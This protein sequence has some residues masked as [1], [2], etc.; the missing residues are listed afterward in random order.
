MIM[1]EMRNDLLTNSAWRGKF[2]QR[3]INILKSEDVVSLV[4]AK[5][6]GNEENAV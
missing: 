3:L 4:Q 6:S 1:L 2:L 5:K